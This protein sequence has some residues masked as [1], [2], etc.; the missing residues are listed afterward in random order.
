MK[1]GI[2]L[3]GTK[4]ESVLLDQKGNKVF[5]NRI[6]TQKNYEGTIEGIKS[7]VSEI[8]KEY[9]FIST[10]GLGMPGSVSTDTSLIKGANSQWLN[11]KPFKKDLEKKLEKV[12]HL[13]NDANCFTLS[14]AVDGAGKNHNLVFGVII[15]TGTGGGIV[16]DKKIIRG[17][18]LIVGE[19]GHNSLP[20][21]SD[22]EIKLAKPCYCGLSGC[23]E[24]FISGPGFEYIFNNTNNTNYK[25]KEIVKLYNDNF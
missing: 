20:R 25:T 5:S 6:P 17:K 13:E 16:I 23:I 1:I 19:F 15:G 8:E 21:T 10:I 14:E 22:N 9:G 24:T 7:L 12:V 3:G 4:T 2:D 18:N 11:G